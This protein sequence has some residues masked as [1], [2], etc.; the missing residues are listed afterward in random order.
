MSRD[1]QPVATQS[2]TFHGLINVVSGSL[3]LCCHRLH[4]CSIRF[5][6]IT[7]AVISRQDGRPTVDE[8]EANEHSRDRRRR[9][10]PIFHHLPTLRSL[11]SSRVR[12]RVLSPYAA[13]AAAINKRLRGVD[14]VATKP[15]A[16]PMF[17]MQDRLPPEEDRRRTVS[18]P[19]P[20][21]PPA[22]CAVRGG[23]SLLYRTDLSGHL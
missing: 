9:L 18:P 5:H 1:Y 17:G 12:S 16:K 7:V 21:P 14:S 11:H 20:P 8:A 2:T 6:V 13:A 19:P 3:K 10:R 4:R 22:A 15:P 23:C